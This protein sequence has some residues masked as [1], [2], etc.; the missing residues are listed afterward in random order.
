MLIFAL[1]E[2]CKYME[3]RCWMY[4]TC[5]PTSA[6]VLP[7]NQ[8][9]TLH[10]TSLLQ[11][12]A[13][14]KANMRLMRD[15]H[16]IWV[17]EK[18]CERTHTHI[19][20]RSILPI[21]APYSPGAH[22]ETQCLPQWEAFAFPPWPFSLIRD[23]NRHRFASLL[24][25]IVNLWLT[26][27]GWMATSSCSPQ[28]TTEVQFRVVELATERKR[29]R[30]VGFGLGGKEGRRRGGAVRHFTQA[31]KHTYTHLQQS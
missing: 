23:R 26:H 1:R 27:T 31:H 22:N 28:S 30:E 19:F 29:T 16:C 3:N 4:V 5:T 10:E 17:E 18:T 20:N 7:C 25:L 13:G 21:T 24:I 14:S 9:V 15:I 8:V 12:I 11:G 2:Y 6:S